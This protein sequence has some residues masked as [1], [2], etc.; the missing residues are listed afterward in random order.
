MVRNG[1]KAVQRP[2]MNAT[3]T[4][5]ESR[6]RKLSEKFSGKS[7]KSIAESMAFSQESPRQTKPKKGPK[8]KVHEF[9][10]FL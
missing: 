5:S 6:V 4:S 2:S 7:Q 3:P 10:P 1:Q 8:R 9:R